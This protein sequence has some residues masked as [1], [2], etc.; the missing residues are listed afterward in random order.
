[1]NKLLISL[2]IV[3]VTLSL[4]VVVR[5]QTTREQLQND[6]TYQYDLYRGAYDEFLLKKNQY[7]ES[8][9]IAAQE[10]LTVAAKEMLLAR[11]LT[12]GV[13]WQIIETNL[14]EVMPF[15]PVSIEPLLQSAK[16]MQEEVANH[17]RIVAQLN[18]YQEMG[19][20]ATAFNGQSKLYDSLT[21]KSSAAILAGRFKRSLDAESKLVARLEAE[22]P[23]QI[24]DTTKSQA[25]LRGLVTVRDLISEAQNGYDTVSK[26]V[27]AFSDDGFNQSDRYNRLVEEVQPAYE[28]LRSAHQLLAELAQGLE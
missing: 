7:E 13:H 11:A 27:T 26:K 21:Y 20:T 18:S 4:A 10:E 28:S 5:A 16:T 8:E 6:F 12:Y 17:Q 2:S 3:G 24:R 1:V 22:I 14:F 25:R 9:T 15:E 19:Y 23:L